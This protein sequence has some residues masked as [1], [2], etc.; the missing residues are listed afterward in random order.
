MKKIQ[1]NELTEAQFRE[2]A[3]IVLGIPNA[4]DMKIAELRKKFKDAHPM[5]YI[6]LNETVITQQVAVLPAG[7]LAPQ[8]PALSPEEIE[9]KA[10]PGIA[11]S[12]SK[13]DP[14]CDIIIA[15][16]DTVD[17]KDAIHP[18]INGMCM[19]IERGKSQGVPLR[20]YLGLKNAKQ[21]IYDQNPVTFEITSREVERFPMHRVDG[22]RFPTEQQ[23]ENY[24]AKD[25]G[26]QARKVA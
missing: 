24:K 11:P 6:L 7:T 23:I 25:E 12:S 19:K 15:E 14:V 20:F 18:V 2:V 4:G 13:S 1:I 10:G 17:G 26:R 8:P 5:D 3:G 9:A 16:T 22:G 21:M